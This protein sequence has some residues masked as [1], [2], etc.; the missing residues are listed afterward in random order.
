MSIF[1]RKAQTLVPNAEP[2]HIFQTFVVGAPV[3]K[4]HDGE[5]LAADICSTLSEVGVTNTEK[6]AAVAADG[7]FHH[8]GVPQKLARLLESSSGCPIPAIWDQAHLMNLAE[9]D[10]RKHGNSRWVR[11]TIETVTEVN[12][13]FSIG[14]GWEDLRRCGEDM[15]EPV[16]RPKLWS[17]TRF[18]AYAAEV[19]SVFRRNEKQLRAALR[20]KRMEETRPSHL[21]ELERLLVSLNDPAFHARV[22]ALEDIYGVLGAAS[23]AVQRTQSLPWERHADQ[24]EA[25]ETIRRMKVALVAK[26][27]F[28]CTSIMERLKFRG[29]GQDV[30]GSDKNTA[31]NVLGQSM[32]NL[33]AVADLHQLAGST[34]PVPVAARLYREAGER[35]VRRKLIPVD[36]VPTEGH[37]ASFDGT[38]EG[39]Y[40]PFL[41]FGP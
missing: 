4:N 1:G 2:D 22:R 25:V 30:S 35:L 38:R 7:Q 33:R 28:F 31:N 11:D 18:A 29:A 39:G 10:A 3:V 40:D 15:G 36:T 23:K 19:F 6:I 37:F 27:A 21:K 32:A 17:E 20:R 9:S 41:A 34:V 24:Q 8:N 5:A 12:K 16:L 13:M 26:I 14:K